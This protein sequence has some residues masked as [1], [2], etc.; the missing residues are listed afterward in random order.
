[1]GESVVVETLDPC[2]MAPE[3][4]LRCARLLTSVWPPKEPPD[5]PPAPVQ[6]MPSHAGPSAQAPARYVIRLP[7]GEI[8]AH[9]LVF[10]REIVTARGRETVLALAAV[11][12][13][14]DCRGLGWGR[15]VVRKALARVDAGDF[16]WALF[17]T[18]KPVFYEKLGCR[19]IDNPI[20]NSAASDSSAPVPW[21]PVVMVYPAA[22]LPEGAIDLLG[23]FWQ[24]AQSAPGRPLFRFATTSSAIRNGTAS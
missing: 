21:D 22:A 18:S 8:G 2:R 3:D 23:P 9:A 17:Q 20:I 10:A 11:C 13:K 4:A 15:E 16:A 1:M 7:D 24:A 5:A 6:N 14:E 12:V 19:A